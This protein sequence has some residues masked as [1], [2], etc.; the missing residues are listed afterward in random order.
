VTCGGRI[1]NQEVFQNTGRKCISISFP[2]T[3]FPE[4]FKNTF[5]P[6]FNTVSAC[7]SNVVVY[8]TDDALSCRSLGYTQ[9]FQS[10]AKEVPSTC[11]SRFNLVGFL[12]LSKGIVIW[13]TDTPF[14]CAKV[15]ASKRPSSNVCASASRIIQ[16]T[17]ASVKGALPAW[18][19]AMSASNV[20]S[21]VNTNF[22]TFAK[23]TV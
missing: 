11:P 22:W 14:P 16:L 20:S 15:C 7:S 21:F 13:P 2:F 18:K 5:P 17:T 4:A 3:I 23:G 1:L 10:L 8:Y 19:S 12:I 6:F 9:K